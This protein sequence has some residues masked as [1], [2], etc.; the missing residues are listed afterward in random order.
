MN[1]LVI[2]FEFGLII[3]EQNSKFR[4]WAP[5]LKVDKHLLDTQLLTTLVFFATLSGKFRKNLRSYK[6]I[7]MQVRGPSA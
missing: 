5:I 1:L 3:V 4:D 6:K 2:Y 7:E